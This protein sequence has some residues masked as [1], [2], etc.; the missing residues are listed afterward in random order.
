MLTAM[1]Y[2]MP[3]EPVGSRDPS[4]GVGVQGSK[5]RVREGVARVEILVQE[6]VQRVLQHTVVYA[7]GQ[8]RPA[9]STSTSNDL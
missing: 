3:V 7:L 2:L 9:A 6:L 8:R 5:H 4:G 1:Q